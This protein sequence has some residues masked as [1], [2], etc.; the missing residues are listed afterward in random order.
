MN[1]SRRNF[2]LRTGGALTMTALATQLRHFGLMSALAEKADEKKRAAA[3]V[4]NDYRA[5]VCIFLA[6][7]NDGNN[8]VIPLHNDANLSNYALYSA[9]REPQGLAFGPNVPLPF[10]VPRIGNLTYGFHPAFGVGANNGLYELWGQNKL[11]IVTNVGSLVKPTTKALMLDENHPK[12]YNMYSH[13]DQAA[14]QQ[15]G[16][17]DVQA[18]TGWAGRISDRRSGADNPGSLVPMITS[19]VGAQL[20]T[21][22]R[23]TLPLAIAGAPVPLSQVLNPQGYESPTADS[24]AQLA[25]YNALRTQ[26][27]SSELIAAAS[28]ITDQAIQVNASLQTSQ[29]VTATFPTSSIGNQLKQVA[30]MI[31]KR[32]DLSVKRQIFFCQINGFDTHNLQL[33]NQSILL[34]QMSQAMRAFYDEMAA[35]G[36]A[37]KVTQFTLSDFGRTMNPAGAGAGVGSDHAWSNHHFVVGG[38]VTAS[39]FY[40]LNTSNGTPYPTLVLDGPDD[41]EFGVGARGRFIPT[42]SIEQFAATLARWF[43]LPETEMVNVFPKIGNFPTS[44]LGFM[45]P[46]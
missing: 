27:L 17:S 34:A 39:D 25:A 43:G 37:D 5:L 19:I 24:Q 4:P 20:F 10:N 13:S 14:Q 26:D 21:A 29:E 23:T 33:P 2:L 40:G 31:K 42:A 41:A 28:H 35:Q 8:T 18:F 9:L 22:G 1:E 15:S 3:A 11:A 12:P 32:G 30:R 45:K 7:G 36:L 6:G 38:G 46:E 44:N 16:R